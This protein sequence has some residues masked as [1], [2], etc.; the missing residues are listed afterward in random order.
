MNSFVRSDKLDENITLTQ[1]EQEYK[2]AMDIFPA[3][4]KYQTEHNSVNL[5]KLCVEIAEFC[6]AV[7]ASTQNENERDIYFGMLEK[8][9]KRNRS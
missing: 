7:Y 6:R 9:N 1:A 8:L 4:H 5:Q 2:E 3:L